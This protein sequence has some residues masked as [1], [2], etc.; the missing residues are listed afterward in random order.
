M[1]VLKSTWIFV[2]GS[3]MR[4]V[5]AILVAL[6]PC[7]CGWSVLGPVP[8]S[9]SL[10][11]ASTSR[12]ALALNARPRSLAPLSTLRASRELCPK[13]FAE[14]PPCRT[15]G[16]LPACPLGAR[17]FAASCCL[18]GRNR[19]LASSSPENLPLALRIS[20]V[21]TR[22]QQTTW[23]HRARHVQPRRVPRTTSLTRT[24]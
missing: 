13:L 8:A 10:R 15:G 12:P 22:L 21:A 1:S 14:S 11:T 3:K 7:A 5:G 17:N 23:G 4:L 2:P 24:T 16:L 20:G 9:M 6:L 19:R 18:A